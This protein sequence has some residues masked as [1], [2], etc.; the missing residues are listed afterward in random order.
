MPELSETVGPQRERYRAHGTRGRFGCRGRLRCCLVAVTFSPLRSGFADAP[1]RGAGEWPSIRPRRAGSQPADNYYDAIATELRERGYPMKSI[2]NWRTPLPVW[3]VGVLPEGWGQVLLMGTAGV[4]W[5]LGLALLGR[6]FGRLGILV[7][8]ATISGAVLPCLLDEIFIMPEVW[9][10]VLIGL[11]AAAY[12]T[13][14]PRAGCLA[15][16]AALLSRELSAPWCLICLVFDVRRAAGGQPR[17][18]PL[19]LPFTPGS[20]PC[21]WARCCRACR[22]TTSHKGKAGCASAEP[23]S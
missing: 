9:A 16:L 7:G 2:F 14:R 13:D 8:M 1:D 12:G 21:I 5:L 3:L 6:E 17:C 20:M 4:M 22:P 19:D 18:G 23:A 10:G 15:A 11:S